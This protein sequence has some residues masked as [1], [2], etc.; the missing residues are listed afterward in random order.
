MV[1][2]YQGLFLSSTKSDDEET[3]EPIE[4]TDLKTHANDDVNENQSDAAA[5]NEPV[6]LICYNIFRCTPSEIATHLY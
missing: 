2:I 1:I 6:S 5:I 4:D 3:E